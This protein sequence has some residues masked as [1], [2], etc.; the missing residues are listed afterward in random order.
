MIDNSI[1]FAMPGVGMASALAELAHPAVKV[2]KRINLATN[3]RKAYS[4]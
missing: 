3:A 4:P 1:S 2:E